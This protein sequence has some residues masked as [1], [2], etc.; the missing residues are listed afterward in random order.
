[1]R[2]KF[3]WAGALRASFLSLLLIDILLTL[4]LIRSKWFVTLT[5]TQ[6]L[7]MIW[8]AIAAIP[9]A[10]VPILSGIKAIFSPKW[11]KKDE[12][13]HKLEHRVAALLQFRPVLLCGLLA[14]GFFLVSALVSKRPYYPQAS[15]VFISS[16]VVPSGL[17]SVFA[18]RDV[19]EK[20]DREI[21]IA[22]ANRG[23][24]RIY[25]AKSL[26]EEGTHIVIGSHGNIP[27]HGKPISV[28]ANPNNGLLYV[29]DNANQEVV[30]I[31]PRPISRHE[32]GQ[33]IK[34]EGN[35]QY[36]PVTLMGANCM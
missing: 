9:T 22:D 2:R 15:S 8:G 13:F 35:P 5:V 30:T 21:W 34:V 18:T 14:L 10:A 29:L 3:P 16:S 33:P 1:M 17:S 27:G 23:W 26:E 12:L 36:M 19:I 11:L 32:I 4:L 31:D 25:D 7:L 6:F 20:A 28:T 24:L